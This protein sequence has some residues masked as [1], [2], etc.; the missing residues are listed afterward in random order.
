MLQ[1]ARIAGLALALSAGVLPHEIQR[2]LDAGFFRYVTKP[3]DVRGFLG[4]IQA[5]LDRRR[6]EVAARSSPE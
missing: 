6:E 5:A 4:V 3:L 2:G 1:Y